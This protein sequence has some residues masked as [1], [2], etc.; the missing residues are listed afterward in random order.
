MID[1]NQWAVRLVIVLVFCFCSLARVYGASQEIRPASQMSGTVISPQE[2]RKQVLS[3]GDKIFV[4][5]DKAFP[6]KKGDRLE[7]FQP[8][9]LPVERKV[10]PPFIKVGQVIILEIIS[11]RLLLGLIEFS[12]REI[13]VGD[14]LYF[15]EP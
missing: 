12:I 6:V 15:P 10:I 8:T 3:S 13:A 2:E 1:K 14:R 9:S 4:S 7:I 5:L 11:D